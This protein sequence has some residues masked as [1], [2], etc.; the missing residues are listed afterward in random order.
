[1]NTRLR[2]LPIS[3]TCSLIL[4]LHDTYED[5]D[6]SRANFEDDLSTGFFNSD[7]FNEKLYRD[8]YTRL[9]N[10][11]TTSHIEIVDLTVNDITH[12]HQH[13]N[14]LH[15]V[16]E[17][18]VTAP[19][20][21]RTISRQSSIARSIT[22]DDDDDALNN[23]PLNRNNA[24]HGSSSRGR[25]SNRGNRRS[26]NRRG[27]SRDNRSNRRSN[28]DGNNIERNRGNNR[29]LRSQVQQNV[30]FV[31]D[32]WNVLL[33]ENMEDQIRMTRSKKKR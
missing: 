3:S 16:T 33:P 19:V 17:T 30:N 24:S 15:E 12:N 10:R 5:S 9:R 32:N 11:S 7:G 8:N 2:R 13:M 27:N 23:E 14:L 25:G 6:E 4:M 20:T 22:H 1:M 31:N 28:N 29:R 26:N 18:P 21:P